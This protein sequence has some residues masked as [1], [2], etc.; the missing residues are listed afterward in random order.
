MISVS[1]VKK[2]VLWKQRV[3][4]IQSHW[5]ESEVYLNIYT[6]KHTYKW[7]HQYQRNLDCSPPKDN[8]HTLESDIQLAEL[9]NKEDKKLVASVLA[10]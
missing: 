8:S 3:N 6:A 4:Y 10:V 5:I 9:N 2:S 1:H 7:F